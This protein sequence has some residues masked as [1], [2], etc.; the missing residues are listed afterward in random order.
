MHTSQEEDEEDDCAI[1]N[2]SLPSSNVARMIC[3][4]KATHKKCHDNIYKSSMSD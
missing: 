1:C 4:G 3:C 2:E